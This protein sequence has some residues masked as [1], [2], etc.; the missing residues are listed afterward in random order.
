MFRFFSFLL[1]DEYPCH[2]K[3]VCRYINGLIS[4]GL[5]YIV[6]MWYVKLN[7][8]IKTHIQKKKNETLKTK[9]RKNIKYMYLFI[10]G[11]LILSIV[12]FHVM[13]TSWNENQL[14]YNTLNECRP[15][16]RRKNMCMH[17]HKK[18]MTKNV[19]WQFTW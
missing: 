17:K 7:K 8:M 13:H 4:Y 2:L 9:H 14:L 18:L 10:F 19:P 6:M 16:W 12:S 3:H 5:C 1:K 11:L 15:Q